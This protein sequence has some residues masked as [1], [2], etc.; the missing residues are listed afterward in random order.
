MKK[1]LWLLLCIVVICSENSFAQVEESDNRVLWL[2]GEWTGVGF[3]PGTTGTS[4]WKIHLN[5]N[6]DENTITIDYPTLQCNGYWKLE[7]L[8]NC[9]AIFK[10]YITDGKTRCDD[11]GTVVV[12]RLDHKFITVSY[13]LP[14]RVEGVIAFSTLTK[15]L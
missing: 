14:G 3:Q 12:T 2:D 15:N 10:E 4:T 8:D 7:L 11:Q 13:F 5:Y 1:L 9:K 6:Y